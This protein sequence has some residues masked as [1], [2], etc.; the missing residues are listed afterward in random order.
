M[1]VEHKLQLKSNLD[2]QLD[3]A[4]RFRMLWS[5]SRN[6]GW[7]PDVVI[8]HSGWG[9]G[10]DVSWVFPKASV[11]ATWNGG[12]VT[13]LKIIDFDPVNKWWDYSEIMRFKLRRRNLN[14]SFRAYQ[15]LI[16]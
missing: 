1:S 3:C 9:C 15:K 12:S 14:I 6:A 4:D 13:R 7:Y 11:L 16:M 2:G 5:Q 10:L 8:S